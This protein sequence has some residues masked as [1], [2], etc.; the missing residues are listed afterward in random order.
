MGSVL[1]H[2][3]ETPDAA[4][5]L[6]DFRLADWTV[7][8]SLDRISRGAEIHKLE[9]R[10]MRL[11]LCLSASAG[12]VVSIDRLLTEVWSG[13]IVG[14]ASVYQS[15]SQLRKMLGDTDPNPTYIATVPR[16]GYRLV[17]P[18]TRHRPST[19]ACAP[20]IVADSGHP[21]EP[22]AL[23][24]VR[25]IAA[26]PAAV[27]GTAAADGSGSRWRITRFAGATGALL[28]M[29]G[30]VTL[31]MK[32]S[33]LP[34]SPAVAGSAPSIVV[35]PFVDLT[36]DKQG[37]FFC[38]GLTEELSNWLAQIPTLKVVASTSAFA[39]R[40]R[41]QDARKI[42][43]A[44]ATDH[45]LE[46]S[47][48]RSGDHMRITVKLIDARNGY[49]LWSASYDRPLTDT[50][51]MQEDISRSVAQTLEIG[52][53]ADTQDRL[54]SRGSDNPQAYRAYL[55]GRH[56]QQERTVA[57]NAEA[58]RLYRTAIAA[59]PK[60]AL[61]YV[62][63][64]YALLNVIWLSDR[65]IADIVRDAEPLLGTALRLDPRLADALAVR[66]ALRGEQLRIEEA[67]KDLEDAVALNPNDAIAHT[68]IGRLYL[69][70]GRPRDALS[71]YG[72]AADLDPLNAQPQA[73]R[74]VALQDLGRYEE[75]ARA[76]A[77]ARALQPEGYWPITVT[78]W[79]ALAQGRL[80]EALEW[81]QAALRLAPDVFDLYRERAES[82]LILGAGSQ[83]RT[84]LDLAAKHTPELLAVD[85]F[86]AE[87]DYFEQGPRGLARHL[88]GGRLEGSNQAKTLFAAAYQ[89]LLVGNTRQARAD[90]AKALWWTGRM[91][92]KRPPRNSCGKSPRSS[93][94]SMRL[95]RLDTGSTSCEPP[96]SRCK[97][98]R[99]EPFAP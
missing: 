91:A 84:T 14:P 45:L 51:Q 58:V 23:P 30:A 88:D 93:I 22:L 98:I 13:V 66:G 18:V 36:E 48:R 4:N 34:P 47:L 8:P 6:A 94:G 9:P 72:H 82:L 90:V 20:A 17:A 65:P 86:M 3:V 26:S 28:V 97:V 52:L 89:R 79:L 76:C 61:A 5:R 15:V 55:L 32:S 87:V 78:S 60:F 50:I 44:L 83:A 80:D 31:W 70:A 19:E 59:D 85:G 53:S 35:L 57:S 12:A 64:A 7:E 69:G 54:A 73:Q 75:A 10:T 67:L 29:A 71:S 68:E 63:L 16:K 99:T 41:E 2:R 92:T 74:C 37:Q 39:F 46:G 49:G 1:Q 27:V 40:G 11:L 81:N 95:E 43:E 62:W 42:G 25:P 21:A 56:H 96:R 33:P 38:D 77:R 24:L